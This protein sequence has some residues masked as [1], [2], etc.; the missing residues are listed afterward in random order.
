MAFMKE[1]PKGIYSLILH[2]LTDIRLFLVLF[3]VH[4]HTL[5][6][7][8]LHCSQGLWQRNFVRS[9]RLRLSIP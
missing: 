5:N 3:S 9:I 2:E 7:E 8:T 4:F 6:K 1:L